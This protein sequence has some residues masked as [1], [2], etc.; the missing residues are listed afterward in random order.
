LSQEEQ[1]TIENETED[2]TDNV[3]HEVSTEKKGVSLS[4]F[5]SVYVHET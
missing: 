3:V 2:F 4:N 5:W 1:Q